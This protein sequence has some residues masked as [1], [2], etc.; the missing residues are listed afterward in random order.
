MNQFPGGDI[1]PEGP[2][3][4]PGY[5]AKPP[6]ATW[7]DH[8]GLKKLNQRHKFLIHLAALG[9][10][11]QE[12]IAK[13]GFTDAWVSTLMSNTQ[14]Q[15]EIQLERDKLYSGDPDQALRLGLSDSVKVILE[16][17]R[18]TQARNSLRVDTA[19]KLMER[20]HG[21]P[22]QS[23]EVSSSSIKDLF[24]RLDAVQNAIPVDASG[25]PAETEDKLDTWI[26]ETLK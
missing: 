26:D 9:H 4:T 6:D 20:T 10:S 1:S 24:D 3:K 23:V 15:K 11:N 14:I 12:I 13:T 19:F 16:T 25:T 22:K 17:I 7:G 18:D 5:E 2:Y 21:K 8:I